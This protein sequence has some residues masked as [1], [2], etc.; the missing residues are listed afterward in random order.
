MSQPDIFFITG[1][2]GS[3]KTTLLDL[4]AR[5][6]TLPGASYHFFDSVGVP[7]LDVMQRDSGGLERWQEH[8]THRWVDQLLTDPEPLAIIEGS[9]RP[10]FILAAFRRAKVAHGGVL[11][12]D[13]GLEERRRR[14]QIDRA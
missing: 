9:T 14:L 12:L 7:P 13:C 6:G 1:A 10:R 4:L 2:S 5:Q 3:G 11:L 8:A